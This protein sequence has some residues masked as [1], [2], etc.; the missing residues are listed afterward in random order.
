MH[1]LQ[2]SRRLVLLPVV[3]LLAALCSS[4]CAPTKS[5]KAAGALLHPLDSIDTDAQEYA[6]V[7]SPDG[8]RLYFVSD[9]PGGVGGHDFWYSTRK[10]PTDTV[11][12]KPINMGRSINSPINEGGM[13]VAVDG[14]TIFF[15]GCNRADGV[16]DCD[17]YT[18][19][20]DG[21]QVVDVHVLSTINSPRWDAQPAIS[22]DG[23]TL[24]FA[25]QRREK[26]EDG[27]IYSSTL[28]ADGSWSTP[29]PLG[30]AVN[31]PADES[32]PWISRDGNRLCFAS[33]R[34]GGY[35]GR[36]LYLSVRTDSG[37]SVPQ[38]LG[39]RF[40]TPYDER[41]IFFTPSGTTAFFAST[42]PSGGKHLDV[43]MVTGSSALDGR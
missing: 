33:N 30:G 4:A 41:T 19:R 18:G 7:L 16:G 31:T 8:L 21:G 5:G 42:G 39:S 43:V 14:M 11:F 36:D 1:T 24:Y 2:Y 17:I 6:P 12:S 28:G 20:I 37:W 22:G 38:N 13:T 23:R 32:A 26:R 35:G 9:R 3:A 15:T 27:D 40:N 25:S 10:S 34:A 29:V